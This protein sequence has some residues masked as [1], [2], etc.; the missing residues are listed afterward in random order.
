MKHPGSRKDLLD[1]LINV[2][3][4]NLFD[5]KEVFTNWEWGNRN[6][7]CRLQSE[8]SNL[9]LFNNSVVEWFAALNYL[10]PRLLGDDGQSRA[11]V[12]P[13]EAGI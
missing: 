7:D 11:D 2:S 6:A 13:A 4:S 3:L 8:V 1:L 12:I 9:R 5:K 10:D